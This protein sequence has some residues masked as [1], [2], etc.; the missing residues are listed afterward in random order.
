[1][2]SKAAMNLDKEINLEKGSVIYRAW[3]NKIFTKQALTQ[4]LGCHKVSSKTCRIRI[5]L[6]TQEIWQEI[7]KLLR[8]PLVA[9]I[10]ASTS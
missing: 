1:M 10:R 5:T 3:G 2:L 4:V 6:I 7:T 8:P 9:Q